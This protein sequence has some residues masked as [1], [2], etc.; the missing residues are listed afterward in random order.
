MPVVLKTLQ[1]EDIPQHLRTPSCEAVFQVVGSD[2]E[3][4]TY[5]SDMEAAM[6]VVELTENEKRSKGD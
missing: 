2:G 3:T 1:G 6:K 5:S 4:F